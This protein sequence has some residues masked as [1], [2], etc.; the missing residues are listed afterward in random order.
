MGGKQQEHISHSSENKVKV[1]VAADEYLQEDPL[2][3][4]RRLSSP[5]PLEA[6]GLGLISGVSYKGIRPQSP[7]RQP[8]LIS[9]H[10]GLGFYI[11]ILKTQSI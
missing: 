1:R 10:W 3:V 4:H 5:C 7:P 11:G 8:P 2:L 9:G 6:E